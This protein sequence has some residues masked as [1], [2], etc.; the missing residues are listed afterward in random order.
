MNDTEVQIAMALRAAAADAGGRLWRNNVGALRD[1][2][3]RLVRYGLCNDSK[4]MNAAI[5]SSDLIGI[6]P[7]VVTHDMVGTVVGI[8]TARE[9]KPTGWVY[10]G[11]AREQ[12]Q[13]RFINLVLSMGG[14]AKFTTGEL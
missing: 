3:G 9:V 7:R 5:K 6:T 4:A 13:L 10:T 8:F 12:A 2:R 14:D 11:T 1:E